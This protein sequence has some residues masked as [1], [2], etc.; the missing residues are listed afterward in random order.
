MKLSLLIS[1]QPSLCQEG[2]YY[3]LEKA[4]LLRRL[5]PDSHGN[6]WPPLCQFS[7]PAVE[8]QARCSGKRSSCITHTAGWEAGGACRLSPLLQTRQG[9][10]LQPAP[11]MDCVS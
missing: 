1:N 5:I 2:I 11:H 8:T 6:L 4:T 7:S 10:D 3:V 9:R